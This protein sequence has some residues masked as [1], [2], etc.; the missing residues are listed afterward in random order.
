MKKIFLL[1]SISSFL[2]SCQQKLDLA[3]ISL[4]IALDSLSKTYKIYPYDGDYAGMKLYKSH[5][6]NLLF[7]NDTGLDGKVLTE[8]FAFVY[9]SNDDQ[10]VLAITL[11]TEDVK[12][13]EKLLKKVDEKFGKADYHY[14]Y[15]D[16]KKVIVTQKI[17]EKDGHYYTLSAG[18]PDY[19]LGE[20]TKTAKL[21]VFNSSSTVFLKWWFYDGGDFSGFYG[22]YLDEI[23]KHKY[24]KNTYTY[25]DFV[26]Q[27][28]KEGKNYGTT[29]EYFVK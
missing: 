18:D 27:M 28:D 11:I 19:V 25:K 8:N 5:D 29:S 6:K 14:H 9:V 16:N 4:P 23:A 7:F 1:V 2:F 15:D 17:W 24:K 13:T 22:Q 10:K 20:K 12:N 26:T 21:T 3:T